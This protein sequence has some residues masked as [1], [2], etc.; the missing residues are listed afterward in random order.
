MD[1]VVIFDFWFWVLDL[2]FQDSGFAGL[3]IACVGVC[4]GFWC[5]VVVVFGVGLVA[6]AISRFLVLGFVCCR[7][8][9][10]GGLW[11]F[12]G[13]RVLC[14]SFWVGGLVGI[15]RLLGLWVLCLLRWFAC[16]CWFGFA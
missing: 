4:L 1:L 12:V 13:F 2:W 7:N 3:C 6:H 14:M 15:W 8:A 5:V 11:L 16:N 10:S 9:G